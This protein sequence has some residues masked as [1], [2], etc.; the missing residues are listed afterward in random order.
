M[1]TLTTASFQKT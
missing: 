1:I